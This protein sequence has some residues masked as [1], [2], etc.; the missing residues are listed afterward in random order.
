MECKAPHPT[1][2]DQQK[3]IEGGMNLMVATFAWLAKAEGGRRKGFSALRL[4]M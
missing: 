2:A 1:L 4:L 3:G